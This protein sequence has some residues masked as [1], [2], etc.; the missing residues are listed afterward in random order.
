MNKLNIRKIN[1]TISNK[2]FRSKTDIAIDLFTKMLRD[3][4]IKDEINIKIE[5]K[6]YFLTVQAEA[7]GFCTE[8]NIPISV[9]VDKLFDIKLMNIFTKEVY[10][11]LKTYLV[12][13]AAYIENKQ[14]LESE[15]DEHWEFLELWCM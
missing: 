2:N 15:F 13:E 8:D 7:Y 11:D 10:K 14:K 6:E 5:K 4:A 9:I 3:I 1:F 12:D